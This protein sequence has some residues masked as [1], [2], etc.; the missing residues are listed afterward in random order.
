MY[1]HVTL[2]GRLGNDP[3]IRVSQSGK[4]VCRLSVATNSYSGNEKRTDWHNVVCFEKQ[5]E[6]CEKFLKKGS[7]VCAEGMLRYDKYK[8]KDGVEKTVASIMANRVVFLQ[9]GNDGE[10]K[11]TQTNADGTVCQDPNA[12]LSDAFGGENI[13]EN[14]EIPF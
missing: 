1:N 3:E 14:E 9:Y 10:P 12:Q 7:M 11:Q 6:N 2:I 4:K 13:K 8:G 5:A